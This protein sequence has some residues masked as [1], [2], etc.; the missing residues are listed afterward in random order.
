[1]EQSIE[2][3][4][5]ELVKI[6]KPGKSFFRSKKAFAALI[7]LLILGF[8]VWRFMAARAAA[9]IVTVEPVVVKDLV[10]SLSISGNI[11]A[12]Q[13]DK[14]TLSVSQ[15]VIDV[16]VKEGQDVK[17]DTPLVKLDTADL[18]YQLK[19]AELNLNAALENDKNSLRSAQDAVTQAQMNLDKAQGDYDQIKKKFD[20]SQALFDKGY[21]SKDE[22][23]ASSKSLADSDRQVKAM[24]LQLDSARRSLNS[25][26]SSTIKQQ[27][28]QYKADIDNLNKKISDS[29]ITASVGGRVVRMDAQ[30][31]EF[32]RSDKNIVM[33]CDLSAYKFNASVSQYDAVKIKPGQKVDVKVKG[34]D[35][36]YK[37]TVTKIGEVANITVSGTS[38]ESK[39]NIEVTVDNLDGLIKVGYE[40]DGDIILK[41][42]KGVVAVNFDS[43]KQDSKG[44]FVYA[45]ENGKVVKKYITTGLET[46]FEV[47]VTDGLKEGDM[48]IPSPP[49]NIKEG[50]KVKE[51]SNNGSN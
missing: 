10:Q 18:D 28:N 39:V 35:T 44:K 26:N 47:E 2:K 38:Q 9:G 32:P 13:T 6:K 16:L 7:I 23:D 19:K 14:T 22:Y 17:A 45:V 15:K 33:V 46:D 50:E 20:V 11:E 43:I 34:L 5:T 12:N 31:G 41:E 48:Y 4:K 25:Y 1:M 40:A 24:Q 49:D 37:G 42:Q 21:I 30:K 27:I 8:A 36:A 3:T 29:T 51:S